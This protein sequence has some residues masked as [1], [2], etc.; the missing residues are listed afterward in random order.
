MATWTRQS[1]GAAWALRRL[2]EG[3][4]GSGASRAR[5]ALHSELLLAVTRAQWQ[6]PLSC[7]RYGT[8]HMGRAETG[9]GWQKAPHDSHQDPVPLTPGPLLHPGVC[10]GVEQGPGSPCPAQ[11][12]VPT[13]VPAG[14]GPWW[15]ALP[16]TATVWQ[17]G[18]G[19]AAVGHAM[20]RPPCGEGVGGRSGHFVAAQS[21]SPKSD[22]PPCAF[23]PRQKPPFTPAPDRGQDGREMDLLGLGRVSVQGRPLGKAALLKRV[24]TCVPSAPALPPPAWLAPSFCGFG[25]LWAPVGLRGRP[26]AW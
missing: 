21:G 10:P 24:L 15:G 9:P 22:H 14:R 19:R 1:V 3:R 6:P 23:G 5:P 11:A 8:G 2:P 13:A 17:G 16:Y 4:R 18:Q 25:A 20:G 7:L 26:A 12:S